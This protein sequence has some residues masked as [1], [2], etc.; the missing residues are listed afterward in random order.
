[1][2]TV[3]TG[4]PGHGAGMSRD[5]VLILLSYVHPARLGAPPD[6]L[7]ATWLDRLRG[8]SFGE[9][10]AALLV[11]G[12]HPLAAY[13]ST[14]AARIDTARIQP[15]GPVRYGATVEARQAGRSPHHGTDPAVVA[16][17][18]RRCPFCRAAPGAVCGP[19]S[20]NRAG[21]RER[22]DPATLLHPS[23]LAAAWAAT[24]PTSET[25]R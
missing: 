1:M 2:S 10:E 17:R 12:P 11:I 21:Q 9:C 25:N 6:A 3:H 23:R 4:H 16:A 18:R 20:R 5:E 13:P 8:Y 19:L 15:P 22:R 14:I 7:V 24:G